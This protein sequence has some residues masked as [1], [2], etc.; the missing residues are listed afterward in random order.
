MPTRRT[1]LLGVLA[2][3]GCGWAPLYADRATEPADAALREVRV[4]PIAE[5]IGQKLELAL[6]DSLNPGGGS[7]PA[8]YL[9]RI[10]LEVARAD[11]GVLTQGVGTR[12]RIDA[13]AN[14]VLVPLGGGPQLTSGRSHAAESFD[15]LANG[16]GNVV[17]E[18]DARTR[19]VEELRRDLVAR[20]TLFFQ[21]QALAQAG[22][23]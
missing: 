15:I 1:L 16:Y 9:L 18:E 7:A 21:R 19:A 4:A 11:L 8:R 20:L 14:Y 13:F 10:T 3:G 17:A 2:L 6:R 12:G 23:P 22:K 5:R